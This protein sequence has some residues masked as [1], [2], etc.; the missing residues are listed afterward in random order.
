[1]R[2]TNVCVVVSVFLS[3]NLF[4]ETSRVIEEVVVTAE[5]RESTVQ[6]TSISITAYSDEMLELRGI[7]NVEDLQ[8]SAP[9]LVISHNSQSPVTYAYIRGIGSDQLVAGFDPGVAYNVDGIYVGQ[10]S[11]MPGDLWDLERIEVLRGPQ[12]TLYGRNTTGGS[13]NL[14]TKEPT[15]EFETFGDVTF[16]DFNRRRIR[17]VVNGGNE[18]VAGRLSFI[19]DEND[20][21]QENLAGSDGDVTDYHSMRG[22]LKFDLSD[23]AELLITAQRFENDGQQSQKK[24]EAFAPVELAPGFIVDVYNGAIPNPTSPRKVAKDYPEDLDLTNTSFNARF[25][26]DWDSVRLVAIS[27]LIRNDWFQTSD[28]DMS[29]NPVQTQDWDMDTRQFSQEFQLVSNSDGPWDWILGVFYFDED[30]DTDYIFDDTSVA[31]FTFMNGG[32]LET[33]SRAVYG[34][35]AYDFRESGSPFKLTAGLRWTKDEKDIFEYQQIPQFA[36]DLSGSMDEDWSEMSGKLAVDWYISD[37]VLGYASYSHGYKGGGFSMGQFDAFDPEKV[38][39]LEI[40]LK[41]QFWDQRAQVNVALFSNDYRDLQVNFL[42][43]TSFTTD[44]AAEASINGLEIESTFLPTDGLTLNV[45]LTWL[46]AT[47]DEYQFTPVIDLSGDTLNRAPEY[48]VGLS[49]QYEWQIGQHGNL[50]ARLDY[51]WQDEVFYR[52]QNIDRH[53]EDSFSTADA[54]LMWNS[55]SGKWSIDGFVKNLGDEDN[56]R[57]L[58]VSDGLSTGNNSF[59]SYYPPR[60]YGVRFGIRMGE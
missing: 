47:F 52:V 3:T 1:M 57:G 8:F 48:T 25:T 38:N 6:K 45:N 12:G 40:G 43:F 26:Y 39:A 49:A 34:Q 33:K 56:L 58:T 17:G 16:G 18:V 21:Y 24:R 5:K 13:I 29:N 10:P 59:E 37:D 20:G 36:V 15:A 22:K 53:R 55:P 28:I 50:L 42:Q 54:V 2:A 19:S 41:S 7:G 14:I 4:A 35:V 32:E 51:Y 11:S 44:N 9:N 31:G 30:L 60:T 27:G 23:R 46:D